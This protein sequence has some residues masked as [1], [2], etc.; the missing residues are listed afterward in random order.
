MA[1][2]GQL[3]APASL[4]PGKSLWYTLHK[5]L[6][7]PQSQSGRGGEEENS[8]PLPGLEP[9]IIQWTKPNKNASMEF[10]VA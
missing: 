9:S 2:S 6:G 1:V 3:H 7:G 5:R 8:Q 4:P 10:H